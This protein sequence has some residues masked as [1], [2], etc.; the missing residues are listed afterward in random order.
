M[1]GPSTSW[2]LPFTSHLGYRSPEFRPQFSRTVGSGELGAHVAHAAALGFSG[3]LYPWALRRPDAEV[4]DVAQALAVSGLASS[5]VLAVP[6]TGALGD[7]WA[8]RS[9]AGRRSIRQVGLQAAAA[10][11]LLSSRHVLALVTGDADDDRHTENAAAGV[12]ELAAVVAD[13]GLRVA[14]EPMLSVPGSLLTSTFQ[15]VEFVQ[16]TGRDDVG[17]IYDTGH[18]AAMGEDLLDGLHRV[19]P[20]LEL[21][22]LADQPGRVEP[23]AGSLGLVEVAVELVQLGYAGLVDLEHGWH[24]DSVAGECAGMGLIR[25]L[26]AAVRART[27]GA[28]SF[29]R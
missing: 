14:V 15:A 25:E 10:A 7:L 5:G 24:V 20:Y 11:R 27:D 13:V 21:A 3:V 23:G 28:H 26:D 1:T 19:A 2:V 8:D 18:V 9:L 29:D 12:A 4:R 16:L 6:E 22:Q 17:I